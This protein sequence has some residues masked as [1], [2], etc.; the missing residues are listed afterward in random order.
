M[1]SESLCNGMSTVVLCYFPFL[2]DK[3]GYHASVN[4]FIIN[5]IHDC[6]WLIIFLTGKNIGIF[7][8]PSG[9][10][11]TFSIFGQHCMLCKLK[12]HWY[13]KSK[14]V[15]Q[16]GSYSG[17]ISTLKKATYKENVLACDSDIKYTAIFADATGF[18]HC[19]EILLVQCIGDDWSTCGDN[20]NDLLET[21]SNFFK[22][23]FRDVC[24][25]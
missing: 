1:C 25:T 12:P 5:N 22:P 19:S 14:N 24:H 6:H 18:M 9:S 16:I 13:W 3:V 11:S 4:I 20:E 21:N 10:A 8:W 7:P 2:Q 17:Q 23:L 15:G